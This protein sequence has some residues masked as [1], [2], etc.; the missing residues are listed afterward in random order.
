MDTINVL[1]LVF[2]LDDNNTIHKVDIAYSDNSTGTQ[3]HEDFS[4]LLKTTLLEFL[5][6]LEA[7]SVHYEETDEDI[8][9]DEF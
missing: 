1:K 8:L 2:H 5:L 4:T 7:S 6:K 3:V 9:S